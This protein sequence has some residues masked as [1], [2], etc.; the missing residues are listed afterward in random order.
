[1]SDHAFGTNRPVFAMGTNAFATQDYTEL[2][3]IIFTMTDANINLCSVAAY[4]TVFNCKASN[5]STTAFKSAIFA[6]NY[7]LIVGCEAVSTKGY[8]ISIGGASVVSACYIHDCSERGISCTAATTVI[9]SCVLDT[10]KIGI[11]LANY[12]GRIINNTIYN[13]N[14]GISFTTGS[15]SLIKNNIIS[16]CATSGVTSTSGEGLLN[17]YKNNLLNNTTN[18]TNVTFD[19]SNFVVDS[20]TTVLTDAANGDFTLKTGDMTARSKGLMVGVNQGTA[21]KAFH[22]NIGADQTGDFPT[23]AN[24]LSTDSV[25]GVQ[26]TF[27]ESDRNTDPGEENVKT[28]TGY[29]ILNVSKNGSYSASGGGGVSKSRIFGGL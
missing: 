25:D 5:K 11:Y 8:G 1:L 23:A 20:G 2:H 29:K 21:D 22:V 16:Q 7:C 6:G 26:G 15:N 18:G 28:G 9:E 24:T 4:C 10:N 14:T 19:S 17:L 13:C 27:V 3:N 12:L